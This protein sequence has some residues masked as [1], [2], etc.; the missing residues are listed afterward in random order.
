MNILVAVDLS[1]AS[2][3]VIEAAR[4]VAE[5]AGV[6]VYVLHAVETDPDFICP[7]SEPVAARNWLGE[8]F[9]LEQSRVQALADKLRR[10]DA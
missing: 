6:C 8:K 4:G 10:C 1:A 7:E 2:D 5:L 9:P 3:I